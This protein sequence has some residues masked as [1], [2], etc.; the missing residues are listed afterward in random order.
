EGRSVNGRHDGWPVTAGTRRNR[1]AVRVDVLMRP[2]VGPGVTGEDRVELN[3]R[4]PQDGHVADLELG[5]GNSEIVQVHPEILT[6]VAGQIGAALDLSDPRNLPSVDRIPQTPA[7]G[8]IR[9]LHGI[10]SV[11]DMSPVGGQDTV[12]V[13][14]VELV[15]RSKDAQ[16][17]SPGIV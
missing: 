1:K 9:Q 12:V 6:G 4:G 15:E 3:V 11:E 17:L 8:G 5:A 2:E 16:R 14:N 10:R 7:L 13:V